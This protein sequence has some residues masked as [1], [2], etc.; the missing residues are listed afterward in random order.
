VIIAIK[1]AAYKSSEAVD[2]LNCGFYLYR[3]ESIRRNLEPRCVPSIHV[4][5]ERSIAPELL[6]SGLT[7]LAAWFNCAQ[8]RQ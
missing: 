3:L 4:D 8:I 6:D 2:K 7:K 1:A 5:R